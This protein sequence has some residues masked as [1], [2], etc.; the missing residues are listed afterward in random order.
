MI[1]TPQLLYIFFFMRN[2]LLTHVYPT[3]KTSKADFVRVMLESTIPTNLV[4]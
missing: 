3:K 4:K 2:F 1:L